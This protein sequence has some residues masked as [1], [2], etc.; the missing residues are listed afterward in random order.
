[1]DCEPLTGPRAR[2]VLCYPDA[3]AGCGDRAFTLEALGVAKVCFAGRTLLP[4]GVRVLGKGHSSVVVAAILD[5]RIPVALKLLR[6]D[7]KRENL[8]GEC[9]NL[10]LASTHG[11]SPRPHLCGDS[12]IVMDLVWGKSLQDIMEESA[13]TVRHVVEALDAAY[14]LDNAGILHAELH[15]P[16]RN[17]Y[18]P[19]VSGKALIIDL[20][21][22]SEGCGNVAKLAQA[23]YLRLIGK[24]SRSLIEALR[25]YKDACNKHYLNE[26]VKELAKA[27]EDVRTL[28]GPERPPRRQRWQ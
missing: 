10:M 17:V 16:W 13:L 27:L 18:F 14:A 21:S 2:A 11:A 23:I 1:M 7:S 12:F 28:R 22:A 15:R 25:G 24:P 5:D 8:W 6:S 20:E 26:I 19:S 9:R 3:R 4:G